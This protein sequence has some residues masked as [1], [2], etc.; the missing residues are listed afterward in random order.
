MEYLI[1]VAVFKL[2]RGLESLRA[3]PVAP[4]CVAHE[5]EDPLRSL[6]CPALLLAPLLV[7]PAPRGA[8]CCVQA[9]R[10]I[11]RPVARRIPLKSSNCEQ[12]AR[13]ANRSKQEQTEAYCQA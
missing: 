3:G 12:K 6:A 9:A 11:P 5:D 13:E 10:V 7:T 8:A 2:E 4:A 1:L